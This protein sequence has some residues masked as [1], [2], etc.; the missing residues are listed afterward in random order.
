MSIPWADRFDLEFA[1]RLLR[2]LEAVQFNKVKMIS[3]MRN[4][5]HIPL[6]VFILQ[7]LACLNARQQLEAFAFGDLPQLADELRIH[8]YHLLVRYLLFFRIL[9][10]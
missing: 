6:A 1:S 3:L 2:P 4:R 9:R 7:K 8:G 5:R 10:A